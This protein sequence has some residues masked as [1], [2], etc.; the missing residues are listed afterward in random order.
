MPRKKKASTMD[1]SLF[2][3]VNTYDTKP[4]VRRISQLRS[5]VILLNI[6]RSAKLYS[7][8]CTKSD[9]ALQLVANVLSEAFDADI[10]VGDC[11]DT[12][13]TTQLVLGA[14]LRSDG[15]KEECVEKI[16]SLDEEDQALLM[17]SVQD[18]M[19]KYP[20]AEAPMF[21]HS[22]DT[23]DSL[24]ASSI[25][26]CSGG[27]LSNVNTPASSLVAS[28]GDSEEITPTERVELRKYKRENEALRDEHES[29]KAHM[30][31]LKKSADTFRNDH[32]VAMAEQERI[33]TRW[34]MKCAGIEDDLKVAMKNHATE[35][36]ISSKK[37]EALEAQLVAL[38]RERNE[39]KDEVDVNK[40]IAATATKATASLAKMKIK[41][42][43][44]CALHEQVAS[45]EEQVKKYRKKATQADKLCEVNEKLEEQLAR[46]KHDLTE[47]EVEVSELIVTSNKQKSEIAVLK[48]ATESLRQEMEERVT[49][50]AQQLQLAKE[51]AE[52]HEESSISEQG[53]TAMMTELNP[54]TQERIQRLEDEN[55]KLREQV[56]LTGLDKLERLEKAL[57]DSERLK[58]SFEQKYH[59][60]NDLFAQAEED[61]ENARSHSARLRV[62]NKELEDQLSE[63][64]ARLNATKADHDSFAQMV[65]TEK[66]LQ[67]ERSET[68]LNDLLGEYDRYRLRFNAEAADLDKQKL[69]M[70]VAAVEF[71]NEKLAM[72]AD[73][74]KLHEWNDAADARHRV[75]LEELR[76]AHAASQEKA[77]QELHEHA[78]AVKVLKSKYELSMDAHSREI[79]KLT[80]EK[81]K[82]GNYIK[83][84]K[85]AY[86]QLKEKTL[87]YEA[88]LK[89][90]KASLTIA[91][92]KCEE[93]SSK[94]KSLE[95]KMKTMNEHNKVLS[96]LDNAKLRSELQTLTMLK[97]SSA[98]E[99][100][101]LESKNSQLQELCNDLKSKIIKLE[102]RRAKASP[103]MSPVR[104]SS[105]HF[106]KEND[107]L[108]IRVS[109]G[110]K[111]TKY[112]NKCY[113]PTRARLATSDGGFG[114]QSAL[115]PDEQDPNCAQQ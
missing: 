30:E 59:E 94:R 40:A 57:E 41:L 54:E 2:S 85:S 13:F 86:A 78:T 77:M 46:Y 82:Y 47:K 8:D 4:V 98:R 102:R 43:D 14:I 16:M 7:G 71:E 113:S 80:L 75:Q 56:D 33:R 84:G 108:S 74:E 63:L 50:H 70:E 48:N 24:A 114:R 81:N 36:E 99:V 87:T 109:S 19:A 53:G 6:L 103:A 111:T 20:P 35:C 12:L 97:N 34:E 112:A 89:K 37:I 28:P 93:E 44:T 21:S 83:K 65:C 60:K 101:Q 55:H 45:L 62:L 69:A 5:G 42:Q 29:M 1:T 49:M 31:S 51:A 18:T 68:I 91:T 96:K 10:G 79:E 95:Q 25:S 105:P 88:M 72:E 27:L 115:N 23:N 100:Q 64:S 15:G 73:M 22:D 61:V 32:S 52:D 90:G 107:G 106:G 67:Y 11:K 39:L 3:W 66:S 58:I 92:A 17:Q 38:T 104:T 9:A 76:A 26:V 110:R